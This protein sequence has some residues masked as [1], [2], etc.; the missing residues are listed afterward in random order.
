MATE[1]VAFALSGQVLNIK[2]LDVSVSMKI[3]D[4]DQSGQASSAA[5]S[6]Q[7]IKA[8]ELKVTGT[9]PYD[10]EQQ[11]QLLYSLAEA[12]DAGGAAKRYRVNHDLARTIKLR[13]AVFSGNVDA[14]K[15]D[16][17]SAWRVNFSLK[18]YFSVAEKKAQVQAANGAGVQVQTSQGTSSATE[19]P[20]QLDGFERFLKKVNDTIGPA[21]GSGGES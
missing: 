18:E 8:K 14:S 7:G 17:L 13:E 9:I 20:E 4:K 2:N 15:E 3:Q 16:G 12:T 6:E 19:T 10:D 11:L 5:K 1:Y 21:L